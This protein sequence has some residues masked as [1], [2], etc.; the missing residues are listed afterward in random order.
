[1][2]HSPNAGLYSCSCAIALDVLYEK[3]TTEVGRAKSR[4]IRNHNK[5]CRPGVKLLQWSNSMNTTEYIQ[6]VDHDGY[7]EHTTWQT[8]PLQMH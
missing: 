4:Q 3:R 6:H 5:E 2:L 8:T 7:L 1:M